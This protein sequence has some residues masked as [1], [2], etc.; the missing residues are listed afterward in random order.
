MANHWLLTTWSAMLPATPAIYEQRTIDDEVPTNN[1]YQ[2]NCKTFVRESQGESYVCDACN[3]Y[4]ALEK[5][6]DFLLDIHSGHCVLDSK[7]NSATTQKA[8][9]HFPILRLTTVFLL[10]IMI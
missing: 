10:K 3:Q 7:T 1:K 2:Q 6:N 4:I 9:A 8:R 5:C